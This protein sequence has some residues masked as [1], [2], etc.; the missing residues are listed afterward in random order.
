MKKISRLLPLLFVILCTSCDLFFDDSS[1]Y[2]TI[3]SIYTNF[4]FDSS[5]SE[6]VVKFSTSASWEISKSYADVSSED[7]LTVSQMQGDAGD[8]VQLMIKVA[9][10]FVREDRSAVLTL[11][12]GDYDVE[13]DV[14]QSGIT[15]SLSLDIASLDVSCNEGESVVNVSSNL[16]WATNGVPE[17]VVLSPDSGDDNAEVTLSYDANQSD[18]S[19]SAE[20]TFYNEEVEKTLCITQAEYTPVLEGELVLTPS[21]DVFCIGVDSYVSFTAAVGDVDVTNNSSLSVFY[22]DNNDNDIDVTGNEFVIK[23]AGSYKFYAK[24]NNPDGSVITSSVVSVEAFEVGELSLDIMVSYSSSGQCNIDF[25]IYYG[26]TQLTTFDE[27]NMAVYAVDNSG[28]TTKLDVSGLSYTSTLNGLYSLYVSYN[29][30]NGYEVQSNLVSWMFE[31]WDAIDFQKR[32]L[33]IQFTA[34]WCGYCPRVTAA[35]YYFEQEYGDDRVVFVSAHG[36]DAMSNSYSSFLISSMGIT[37]FPTLSVGSVNSS[38][39]TNVGTSTNYSHSVI[40]L[41]SAVKT[42]EAFGVSTAIAASSLVKEDVIEINATIAVKSDGKYGVGAMVLED[43]ITGTQSTYYDLADI[44]LENYDTSCHKNVLQCIYPSSQTI[45]YEE[46]GGLAQ[47][48]ANNSYSFECVLNVDDL[49]S[50]S[51]INNCRVVV[52]T[53]DISTGYVDNIIQAPIGTIRNFDSK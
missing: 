21:S 35:I 13:I 27:Q 40:Y 23:T 16:P 53:Y 6:Q 20:I 39:A 44:G 46:L 48:Y 50:L 41:D 1:N 47:H 9:E 51:D 34:T 19:R 49:T 37:G 43:D 38:Y 42:I 36:S 52:Y 29:V 3:S 45:P 24:Y 12:S 5:E 4:E 2:L 31:E 30:Y 32:T 17:W 22:I 28:N 14:K 10:N 11:F 33:G 26:Q 15:P 25:E 8:N 18:E 7:W